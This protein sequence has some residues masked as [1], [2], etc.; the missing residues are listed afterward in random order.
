MSRLDE[1]PPDQRATLSLLLQQSKSYAQVAAMLG[2]TERAVHDRAHAALALLAPSLA[3]ELTPEQRQEVGDYL[4]GAQPIAERLRTRS[5]IA[6][7]DPARAWAGELAAQLAPLAPAN[8]PDVPPPAAPAT[9]GADPAPRASQTTVRPA[10]LVSSAAGAAPASTPQGASAGDAGQS[11]QR[12]SRVGGAVLLGVLAAAVIV[13]V[14][15][16]LVGGGGGGSGS[17]K[18][19]STSTTSASNSKEPT[20]ESENPVQP[21]NAKSKAV[22]VVDVV[23][24]EGSRYLLIEARNLPPA[25]GFYY[26]IWLYNSP[27]SAL[28]VTETSEVKDHTLGGLSRVPASAGA[29]HEILLTEETN[30][31]PPHPGKIVL[32]GHFT[33]HGTPS[34]SPGS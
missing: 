23:S 21:P 11:P 17:K 18:T 27:T 13:V 33:L 20:L 25:K 14:V 1:L 15:V 7:S 28:P 30:P 16:L 10:A 3:R 12:S 29:Y 24:R 2:I 6:G 34:T 5:Y 4:L 32:R 26:A 31:R 9:G 22:G 19:T 8:L